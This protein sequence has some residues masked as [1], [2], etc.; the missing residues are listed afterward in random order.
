MSTAT[1]KI[2]ISHIFGVGPSTPPKRTSS[3]I[4][5]PTLVPLKLSGSPSS[6]ASLSSLSPLPPPLLKPIVEP[7]HET[8]VF[9]K[10]LATAYSAFKPDGSGYLWCPVFKQYLPTSL[11]K[12]FHII[13]P[14][15]YYSQAIGYLFGNMKDGEKHFNSL[16]NGMIMAKC[17]ANLVISGDFAIIPVEGGENDLTAPAFR[18]GATVEVGSQAWKELSIEERTSLL[19]IQDMKELIK[20]ERELGILPADMDTLNRGN[21]VSE[22]TSNTATSPNPGIKLKL[23]LMKPYN[24]HCKIEDM[25]LQYADIHNT[26]LEFKSPFRPDIRYCYFRYISSILIWLNL[27]E[28]VVFKNAWKPKGKWLRESLVVEM[29]RPE[30]LAN[31]EVYEEIVGGS[32]L[33]DDG[34]EDGETVVK[35]DN[36]WETTKSGEMAAQLEWGLLTSPEYMLPPHGHEL[37]V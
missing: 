24:S 6:Q 5:S 3:I 18:G 19:D 7:G 1:P 28:A 34:G 27:E 17:I 9:Q 10:A 33:F 12:H 35:M 14:N 22:L 30:R 31:W 20:S 15:P 29:A 32:G 8:T 11:I 25:D 2:A 36:G 23:V 4:S 13:N 21:F 16:A 26:V 37:H